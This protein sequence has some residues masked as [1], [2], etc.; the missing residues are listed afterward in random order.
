[1]TLSVGKAQPVAVAVLDASG[2]P[3]TG[4]NLTYTLSDPTVATVTSTGEIKG[5][6]E[7]T[8]TLTVTY[9]DIKSNEIQVQI[10]PVIAKI[11]LSKP[12]ATVFINA[13]TLFEATAKD[14]NG[15]KIEGAQFT[16][17]SSNP[18]V[19]SI[20][21]SGMATGYKKGTTQITAE[22]GGV[23]SAPA[24]LTI[25]EQ[26]VPNNPPVANFTVT[27]AAAGNAPF[28]V[29]LDGSGSTDS[30]GSVAS[31]S[32]N[33]GDDLTGAGKTTQHLY[34]LPGTYTITLT[35]IDDNGATGTR[36]TVIKVNAEV[37]GKGW[38]KEGVP[39]DLF[40]VYFVSATEGWTAGLEQNIYHT[41][42]GGQ[43]SETASGWEKQANFVW[44][45]TPPPAEA[46]IDFYDLFFVN[47]QT[48]WAVGWP[49]AIFKTTDG[50]ATWVEQQ[51]NRGNWTPAAMANKSWCEV[52]TDST[53]TTCSKKH[54]VYLRKV[55]FLDSQHG[56][57]VGRFGYVFKT[58]D[59]GATWVPIS[60]KYPRALPS[61]CVYPSWHPNA[62]QPRPA[63]TDY[64]PHLFSVDIIARDEVWVGGGSEG[65]EP[66]DKGWL[67]AIMHTRDGGQSWDYFY[68]SETDPSG[69]DP[70][71]QLDGNGRIFDLKFIGD[72]GWAV[73]GVGTTNATALR[74]DAT[75]PGKQWVLSK[76]PSDPGSGYYGLSFFSPE[77]IWMAGWGG[78]IMQSDD[79][80]ATW[81]KQSA[82][83][84]TQL[85]RIFFLDEKTG[86]IAGQ[87]QVVRTVTGGK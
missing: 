55:Q 72:I 27:P 67:R 76:T 41:V 12:A 82:G 25:D 19:A 48:G 80:G 54:G 62:G 63:V 8:T 77:K 52:W 86:W 74:Y 3:I 84:S 56:W 37:I 42:N 50:G 51:L 81:N 10:F 39:A 9:G 18:D 75:R 83:T 26:T 57:A 1:V 70:R 24:T 53:K 21:N 45:G 17:R 22:V 35:V 7:G 2:Q 4:V 79:G 20:M 68:E 36:T 29:Q 31:Y 66:C 61:P 28:N 71:A 6:H 15:M 34:R 38:H 33:F 16:W 14:S 23:V 49:E 64:N 46:P 65:D 11:E 87:G 73:G 32:W 59:G 13:S 47:A 58:D 30:D 40:G 5:L 60:Q 43:N 78:L 69:T 85:R 44:K